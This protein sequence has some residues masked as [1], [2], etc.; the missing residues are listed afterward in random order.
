MLYD[1]SSGPIDPPPAPSA[2]PV[3]LASIAFPF[4]R[5]DRSGRVVIFL[6]YEVGNTY[7][8]KGDRGNFTAKGRVLRA[9]STPGDVDGLPV[10][11]EE[12]TTAPQGVMDCPIGGFP[13]VPRGVMDRPIGELAESCWSAMKFERAREILFVFLAIH[14]TLFCL[15]T[16]VYHGMTHVRAIY[17]LHD[18]IFPA[19]WAWLPAEPHTVERK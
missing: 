7:P 18:A 19:S 14:L 10:I 6:R 13:Q 3:P 1:A 9:Q 5:L 4:A 16:I 15:A 8:W 12:A 17:G 2:G 11:A